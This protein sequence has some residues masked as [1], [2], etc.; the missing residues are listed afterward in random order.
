MRR[1]AP[2]RGVTINVR[3]PEALRDPIDRA[4]KLAGQDRSE[5]MLDSARNAPRTF[6]WARRCSSWMSI[7]TARFSKFSITL[8][9]RCAS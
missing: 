9:G 2:R 4:A 8:R 5:F 1:T 7:A 6:C 3:A